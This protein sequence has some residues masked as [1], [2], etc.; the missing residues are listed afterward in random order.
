MTGHAD[1]IRTGLTAVIAD[2]IRAQ[3]RTLQTTIGPSEIG[4]PCPRAILHK[5]AGT[6]DPRAGEAAWRPAVGTAIHAQLERWFRPHARYL[7]EERVT[8]GYHGGQDIAGTC[9]LYDL[10]TATVVDWKTCSA[11]KLKAYKANGPSP[12]YRVQAHLYGLGI[13]RS[14]QHVPEHVAVFWL[15]RDGDLNKRD[16]HVWTEPFNPVVALDALHRL[17]ALHAELR[18][19]GLDAALDQ[20]QPCTDPWCGWCRDITRPTTTAELFAQ[21]LK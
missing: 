9:D 5:L 16:T 15:M 2:A 18:L 1:T 17:D 3:P 13:L 21:H 11:S 19:I 4:V 6:P 12:Q 20:Y 14:T 7:V 10:E 8:I